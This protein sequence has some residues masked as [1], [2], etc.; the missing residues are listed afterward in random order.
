[1]GSL[2]A[3][4]LDLTWQYTRAPFGQNGSGNSF[5]R[6]VQQVLYPIRDITSSFVDDIAVHSGEFEQHLIYFE[7]FP[8]I[9][10]KSVFTLNLKKCRFAQSQV[11]YLGHIIGSG[12][13]KPGDEKVDTVKYMYIPETKK[14]VRISIG[15]FSYFR[16]YIPNFAEIAQPLTDLTGK[17]VPNRVPWG[18]K[19]NLFEKLKEELCK[20]TKQSMSIADFSKTLF[21]WG[22]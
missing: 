1:M 22:G 14:K 2:K 6:A 15:F 17:R 3:T 5:V 18:E 13:R 16:D 4:W 7:K 9:I 8:K 10:K 12:I 21:D 11:K 20:A 19:E